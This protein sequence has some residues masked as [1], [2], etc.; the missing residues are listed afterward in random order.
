MQS[1]QTVVWITGASSGIGRA[2]AG[3][4][5]ATG[6]AVAISARDT[7]RLEASAGQL[8]AEHPGAEARLLAV[9]CDVSHEDQVLAAAAVITAD[10]GRVDVLVNNAGTSVFK[11]FM[12]SSAAD[13]DAL[14]SVNLRGP[15]LCTQAVLPGMVERGAGIVVMINSI[16]ARQVFADSS[17]YSATKA[18]LRALADCLRHEVRRQGVRVISV[19]PGATSTAIW[20]ARVREK[21]EEKMLRPEDVA[22][23][24]VQACAAP[25]AVH[26]ED[27]VLQPIGGPL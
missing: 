6:A 27:L 12:Q 26:I 2:L 23:A 17:V 4:F 14:C 15:F 25:A 3:R 1:E 18:G 7:E 5:L 13:F 22:E 8:R 24:I 21:Y 11:P 19:Y 20:P 10:F 16:T 9:R